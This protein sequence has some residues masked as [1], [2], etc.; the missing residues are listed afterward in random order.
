MYIDSISSAALERALS[1]SWQ[2]M[3]TIAGNIANED[4]PG[5]KAKRVSFE[6]ALAKELQSAIRSN[7][8][9]RREAVEMMKRI[10]SEEYE[11]EG[12]DERADGNNVSIENEQIEMA[13]IQMQYDMLQARVA[14]RYSNLQLAINGSR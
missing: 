10:R 4:T 3:R 1:V 14:G 7:T 2:R 9:N 11:L 5:Y 12:L 13:R 6:N 8:I